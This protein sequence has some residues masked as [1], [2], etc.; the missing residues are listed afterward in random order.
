MKKRRNG[1]ANFYSLREEILTLINNG[2]TGVYIYE[3][4][5]SEN[6]LS[7][8]YPQFQRYLSEIKPNNKQT[9]TRSSKVT[10]LGVKPNQSPQAIIAKKHNTD[11]KPRDPFRRKNKPLHNPNISDEEFKNLID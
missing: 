5:K 8:S 1:R 3:S 4:L 6:K 11:E 9:S 2:H 10:P 7:I